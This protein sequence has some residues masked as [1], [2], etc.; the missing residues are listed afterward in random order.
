MR[1]G[2]DRKIL[3]YKIINF[4]NQYIWSQISENKGDLNVRKN[5]FYV[6]YGNKNGLQS[7]KVK[8]L[9]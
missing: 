2:K 5:D 1:K 9:Y 4:G 8:T 7:T 3:A 6:Q